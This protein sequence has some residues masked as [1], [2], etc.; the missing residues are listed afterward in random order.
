VADREASEGAEVVAEVVASSV[1]PES[2]GNLGS[3]LSR[4]VS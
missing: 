2:Q 1:N 3:L 4:E